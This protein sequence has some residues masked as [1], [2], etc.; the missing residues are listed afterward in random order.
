[1][2]N[3]V[4][5]LAASS[6]A[7][8]AGAGDVDDDV[9]GIQCSSE[10]DGDL[11]FDLISADSEELQDAL[12]RLQGCCCDDGDLEEESCRLSGHA[13][14]GLLTADTSDA[15]GFFL[16]DAP[17]GGTR[18]N[19]VSHGANGEVAADAVT[20]LSSSNSSS[21]E[22]DQSRDSNPTRRRIKQELDHLRER[23]SGLEAMLSALQQSRGA[24]LCSSYCDMLHSAN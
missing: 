12:S 20:P 7:A 17:V 22:S 23:V 19:T 21:R 4:D 11:P 2:Q 9:L 3:E 8:D 5:D 10:L 18:G 16:V 13:A 14:G 6:F 15:L 24:S 1:M